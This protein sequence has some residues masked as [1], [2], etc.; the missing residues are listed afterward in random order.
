MGGEGIAVYIAK[1]P[2][3]F[4]ETQCL[5]R[6]YCHDGTRSITIV[7]GSE[8]RTT[9][10]A[11]CGH[12]GHAY[13]RRYNSAIHG[14]FGQSTSACRIDNKSEP[15]KVAGFPF[16]RPFEPPAANSTRVGPEEAMGDGCG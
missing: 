5:T 12:H 9:S 16:V 2:E 10:L 4:A 14:N 11:L 13:V 15:K 7:G 3:L 6:C 1:L 8:T